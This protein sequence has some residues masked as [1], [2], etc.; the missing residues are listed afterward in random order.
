MLETRH[1]IVIV[2]WLAANCLDT[3]STLI[4]FSRGHVEANLL[5]A[6]LVQAQGPVGLVAWKWAWVAMVP[7][8]IYAL[9]RRWRLW[10]ALSIGTALVYLAVLLNYLTLMG[11]VRLPIAS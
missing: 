9:R 11:I 10:P 6:F 2:N 4:G 5:P 3:I 7:L 1:I 8:I